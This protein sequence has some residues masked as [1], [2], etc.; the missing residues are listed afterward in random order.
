M[1]GIPQGKRVRREDLHS[2]SLSPEWSTPDVA[3]EA[4]LRARFE[5]TYKPESTDAQPRSNNTALETT[6]EEP[7]DETEAFDFRLFSTSTRKS[8]NAA[9]PHD[10]SQKIVIKSPSPESGE[11]GFTQPRRPESYYFTGA[12]APERRQRY[13]EVA[14]SG[15]EIIKG[16]DIHY[17]G[18]A[19]PWRVLTL[20]V[21]TRTGIAALST[22]SG[23]P[24]TSTLPKKRSGK[25]RRILI[26]QKLARRT[27]QQRAEAA[28][29]AEKEVADRAKRTQ[30]NREKKV[31]KKQR[32][33][34]KRAQDAG[35]GERQAVGG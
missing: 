18:W 16:Q 25:K 15:P 1:F 20:K 33:K 8:S 4:L 30:R 17:P 5:D 24:P 23:P 26:R 12:S 9:E 6:I 7:D 29:L 13:E 14:I 21:N 22:S 28:A 27:A 11:P 31:K 34:A 32:D 35:G 10:T 3:L 19:L 2:R